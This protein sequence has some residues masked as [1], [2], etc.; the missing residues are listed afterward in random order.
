MGGVG[1]EPTR[2]EET[3]FTVRRASRCSTHPFKK[4]GAPPPLR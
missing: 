4:G 3:A 2:S 1:L